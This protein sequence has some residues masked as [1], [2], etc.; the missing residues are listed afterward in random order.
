MGAHS[1]LAPR[2]ESR[3]RVVSD[4]D[5]Y[6]DRIARQHRVFSEKQRRA[7]QEAELSKFK[8]CT[9]RPSIH[10]APSY[11]KRIARSMA[12]S[13]AAR[14]AAVEQSEKKPERPEWR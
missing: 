10:D 5:T 9:F 2:T 4:P 1:T 3:L 12:L 11:V 7:A 13:K 14:A 8:E 6:L